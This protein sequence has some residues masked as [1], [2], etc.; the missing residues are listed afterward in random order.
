MLFTEA[1]LC[2]GVGTGNH[3]SKLLCLQRWEF[4]L[5]A[6]R[7]SLLEEQ[8]I[9]P[10]AS[11]YFSDC[12]FHVICLQVACLPAPV[13]CTLGSIPA[14]PANFLNSKLEG[15]GVVGGGCCAHAGLLEEVL[16]ILEQMQV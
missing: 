6:L 12:Y 4:V 15:P 3:A 14:R 10:H 11:Q 9:F 8:I 1:G 7:E 16:A 13:Q 5:A 2:R